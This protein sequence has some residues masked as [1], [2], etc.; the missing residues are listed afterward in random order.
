MRSWDAGLQQDDRRTD[1]AAGYPRGTWDPQNFLGEDSEA[2]PRT[3][4]VRKC[5]TMV[6]WKSHTHLLLPRLAL[7]TVEWAEPCGMTPFGPVPASG[8]CLHP[9]LRAPPLVPPASAPICTSL[10]CC[11]SST[12][13]SFSTEP[14]NDIEPPRHPE[15]L[16]ISR[17]LT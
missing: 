4:A 1:E 8:G 12:P 2:C 5:F 17:S 7:R 9:W 13:V 11:H 16:P 10:S 14:Y 3:P 6:F 15:S